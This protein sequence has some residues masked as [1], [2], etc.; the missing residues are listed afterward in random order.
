MT[1]PSPCATARSSEGR[2]IGATKDSIVVRQSGHDKVFAIPDLRKVLIKTEARPS[3]GVAPGIALG[4]YIGN[5][6]LVWASGERLGFTSSISIRANSLSGWLLLGE[7]FFAAVGAGARLVRRPRAAGRY[8]FEFPSPRPGRPSR[9]GSV[10]SVFWPGEPPPARVHFLIQSGFLVP[11]S[12]AQFKDLM[13]GS[14][15][16][17]RRPAISQHFQR[18]AG[19]GAERL[20]QTPAS[21]RSE[22]V[23]PLRA[24][25][26]LLLPVRSGGRLLVQRGPAG[27]PGHGRPRRR[28]LRVGRRRTG[29]EDLAERGPRGRDRGVRLFR[30]AWTYVSN[31]T[32]YGTAEVRKTLLSGVVFGALQSS[33]PCALDRPGR[34][35]HAHSRGRCPR[36]ARQR[37]G[38]P[39][40]RAQQ[41]VR[42][43]RPR[44]SLLASPGGSP[45]PPRSPPFS[46]SRPSSSSLRPAACGPRGRSGRGRLSLPEQ[47]RPDRHQDQR[48]GGRVQQ[49]GPR[50]GPGGRARG[51]ARVLVN[52]KTEI[53]GPFPLVK[54]RADGTIAEVTDAKGQVHFVRT[55]LREEPNLL[56][57]QERYSARLPIAIPLSDVRLV[58]YKKTNTVLTVAAIAVVGALNLFALAMYSLAHE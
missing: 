7:A 22:T 46:R 13:A 35:L 2:L 8:A 27:G 55:V 33:D 38:R 12:S 20:G 1:S 42:R 47:A 24:G 54:R 39:E 19:I 41:R 36:P 37:P 15:Y 26:R 44:L 52:E 10:S 11:G 28:R 18:N 48:R 31:E 9:P 30:Q 29:R 5:G 49:T 57:V 56:V 17:E 40:G 45:C 21:G 16:T 53:E 50:D 34:R 58:T 51:T 25:L 4:L 43:I 3:A 32:V 6:L 14:G 23:L